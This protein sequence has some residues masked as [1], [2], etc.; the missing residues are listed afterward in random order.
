MNILGTN[1]AAVITGTDTQNLTETNAILTTGGTL[2]V[3]DVDSAATFNVQSGVEGSGGFGKFSIN[4]A[5][6]WSY[7]TDTAHDEFVGGITYT[8]TLTV[9]V[10][11]RHDASADGEHSRHQRR[12]GDY[13]HVERHAWR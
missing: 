1:D 4:A 7:V 8:D 10:G 2:T 3:S 13:R 12:G 5:G 11:G 6:V 9:S